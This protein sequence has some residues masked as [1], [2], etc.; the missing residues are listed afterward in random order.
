[1]PRRKKLPPVP[2]ITNLGKDP[3]THVV[4]KSNPLMSLS[5]TGLTLAEFKI[6]DAYLARIDSHKPEERFVRLEKGEIEKYLGVSKI[7]TPDLEKRIDNLFQTVTIRDNHKARGFTKIALFEK[8]VCYQDDDGLW[9]IDLGASASAM[10]YIFN[11]E[12]IGYLR[13]RLRNVINLTSRYSYVLYLYLE[14]N[15]HMHLS[16]EIRLDELKSLLRCTAET[17][18]QY[19]RFNDLILKKCHKELNEKT[20]CHFSYEPVK[21]GRKVAAIR[22]TLEPITPSLAVKAEDCEPNQYTL[23]DWQDS[24]REDICHGFESEEFASFT[25][26]QLKVLRD[27]GWAKKRDEDVERHN[28]LLN[29]VLLACQY[30]TSDYLRQ[31]ILVAKTRKPKNLFLY[32]KKMIENDDQDSSCQSV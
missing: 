18:S 1:M 23:D 29:D 19:K 14:Q 28:A 25:D 7:N 11:V 9:Q 3:E 17:Y 13:Y 22:F 12:N 30:A 21:K 4:Q 20:E 5:E 31:K 32:V 8:A 15:R 16:W 10:D 2:D 24:R 26:E 27:L 6:L